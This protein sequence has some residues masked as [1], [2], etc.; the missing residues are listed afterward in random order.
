MEDYSLW[1]PKV[2]D[3]MVDQVSCLIPLQARN[4][5]MLERVIMVLA[6]PDVWEY[7]ANFMFDH[8]PVTPQIMHEVL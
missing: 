2:L 3:D 8:P 4:T 1:D 6:G 7:V 5:A